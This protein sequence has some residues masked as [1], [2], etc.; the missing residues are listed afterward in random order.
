MKPVKFLAAAMIAATVMT[1]C[2]NDDEAV[3]SNERVE[4]KFTSAQ[5]SVETRVTDNNWAKNDPIGIYMLKDDYAL[6]VANIS[7]GVSN[8]QYKA[9]DATVGG[10]AASFEQVGGTIYYPANRGGQVVKVKFIAYYPYAS[11]GITEDFKL[12]VNVS[13]QATQSAIDFLHAP[14]ATEYD[15]AS[16]AVALP[17]K[18]KLVKLVF[19]IENGDGVSAALTDLTV[20]I[21]N[22]EIESTLDLTDGSVPVSTGGAEII[23]AL[24]ADNGKSSEAI[25]LPLSDTKDVRFIF[26][27]NDGEEF[28]GGV[29]DAAWAGG[30]KYTYT[31]KLKKNAAVITGTIEPWVAG[32]GDGGKE[33]DAE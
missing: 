19:A 16:G 21:T 3:N 25:V 31:V 12:P 23:E 26:T 33:I 2:S 20:E 7:E 24:T 8:R 30:N 11:T 14:A 22:Q 18:H 13:N 6:T 9:S 4:V 15:K 10:A 5:A 1:S 27:N 28:T 17:F 32:N 29:P